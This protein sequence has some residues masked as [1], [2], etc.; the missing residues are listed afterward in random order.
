MAFPGVEQ[1]ENSAQMHCGYCLSL[2]WDACLVEVAWGA[3]L[4]MKV[5]ARYCE[6]WTMGRVWEVESLHQRY[7]D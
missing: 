1:E 2:I 4:V 7:F 6:I 5:W 3:L